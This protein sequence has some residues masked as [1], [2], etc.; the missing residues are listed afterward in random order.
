MLVSNLRSFH[1]INEINSSNLEQNVRQRAPVL[2][3]YSIVASPLGVA[4]VGLEASPMKL[5]CCGRTRDAA[6]L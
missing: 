2:T 6:E 3:T 4:Y 1:E 5:I